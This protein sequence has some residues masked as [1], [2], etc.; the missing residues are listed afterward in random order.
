MYK[1]F[2]VSL[3]LLFSS[4][5]HADNKEYLYHCPTTQ[6]LSYT[7][8]Y[9]SSDTTYNG[10]SIHWYSVISFP[11]KTP[12]KVEFIRVNRNICLGGVCEINCAYRINDDR[13]TFLF[14]RY[15][16]YESEN[17]GSGPWEGEDNSGCVSDN[18]TN[19]QFYLK[20]HFLF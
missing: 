17:V 19:C 7:G 20:E 4:V 9:F 14:I 6:E 8:G 3:I 5:V 12:K 2:L 16:S 10:L 13:P 11:F 1:I 15:N 18:P